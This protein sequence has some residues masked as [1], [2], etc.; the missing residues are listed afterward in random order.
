MLPVSYVYQVTILLEGFV[1]PVRLPA[2]NAPPQHRPAP[3]VYLGTIYLPPAVW[4]APLI[5]PPVMAV[6]QPTVFL[7]LKGFTT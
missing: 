7:V 3:P 2:S 4:S 5:V 6:L 1:L